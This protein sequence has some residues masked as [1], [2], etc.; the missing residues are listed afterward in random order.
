MTNI[1]GMTV[2]QL[3]QHILEAQVLLEKKKIEQVE[4]HRKKIEEYAKS[5]GTSLDEVYQRKQSKPKTSSRKRQVLYIDDSG[6]PFYRAKKEWTPEQKAK[7][8]AN[9]GR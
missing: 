6:K 7:F 4:E 3:E 2:V 1:S 5:L 9:A 8:K